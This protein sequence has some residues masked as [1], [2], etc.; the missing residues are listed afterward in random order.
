QV[1]S[2]ANILMVPSYESSLRIRLASLSSEPPCP[3]GPLWRL[4]IVADRKQPVLDGEPNTFLDQGPCDAGNAGAVGALSHQLFEIADGGE[5]QRNRNAVGFGF[6]RG[7][8]KKLAFNRCTEK[9]LFRVYLPHLRCVKWPIQHGPPTMAAGERWIATNGA[10]GVPT[11][12]A[13]TPTTAPILFDRALLR[14]RQDRALR[15]GPATFLLDRVAEEMA[16]RLHAVLRE[17]KSAADVGTPG[18]QV[19]NALAGRLNQF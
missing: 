2:L 8:A 3:E 9:Y 19:H 13:H 10:S 5:R 1:G 6:F 12:M 4:A 17:F 11:C 15:A 14:A 18:D 7:H 16:E